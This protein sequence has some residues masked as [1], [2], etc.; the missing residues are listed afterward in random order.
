MGRIME[1]T[2]SVKEVSVSSLRLAP[3]NPA[4]VDAFMS[5]C[6]RLNDKGIAIDLVGSISMHCS[7]IPSL[8]QVES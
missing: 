3:A 5:R 4:H 1:G 8:A 2:P 7:I 6:G